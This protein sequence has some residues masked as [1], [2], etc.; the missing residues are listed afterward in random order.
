MWGIIC[1]LIVLWVLTSSGKQTYQ[2][3]NN[4]N[5]NNNDDSF[6][7][8]IMYDIVSDGD[9]DGNFSDEY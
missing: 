5:N 1:I 9:L 2:K 7:D 6:D 8:F 4:N 3:P